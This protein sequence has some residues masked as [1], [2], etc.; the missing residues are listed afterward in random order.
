MIDATKPASANAAAW[1][2]DRHVEAGNGDRVAI[3]GDELTY[4]GLTDLAARAG[5]A[6]AAAG[7]TR[8]ERVMVV[9]PDGIEAVACALGAM[10]A[11]AVPVLVSPALSGDEQLHVAR[12]CDA[13]A[14]VLD[15]S[16]AAGPL[17]RQAGPGRTW[18]LGG[19]AGVR[20]LRAELAGATAIA[21]ATVAPDELALLQ[22]TSGSSGRPKGV[23]HL[24]RGLLAA[25]ACFGARLGLTPDD[26]VLST[27]KLPFGYGFGN[28]V[29]F[30]LAAGG[31]VV[32]NSGPP[33][34][35]VVAGLLRKHRPTVLCAVPAFYGAALRLP[36]ARERLDLTSVRLLVSAGEHLTAQL[37]EAWSQMFGSE[38]V[39][40]L[41]S[42]ECLHIFLATVAG[43]SRAG[44]SG[45]P[46]PGCELR[47]V[48][49][50]GRD[51]GCSE[52]GRLLVRSPMNGVGYWGRPA[53]TSATFTDG[54]V[55]TGDVLVEEPD[56]E[57][58][59]LAR[60]D[61]I[62]NAGGAKV[63]PQDVEA[64]VARHPGVAD[65]AVVSSRTAEYGLEQILAFVVAHEDAGDEDDLVRS[66]RRHVRRTLP[67]GR[68]PDAIVVIDEL[69]RTSTGKLARFRL[70]TLTEGQPT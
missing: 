63:A 36:N 50:D 43:R 4:A 1:L 69:P 2:L 38:I 31:S 13:A 44:S 11:G 40:G 20:D 67:P 5:G 23:I 53:A 49:D 17:L 8:G 54:W 64:H 34:V 3:A 42:T 9:L 66:L 35:H 37:A 29:L 25:P 41:G 16:R 28:S 18:A 30:P 26:R 22:Y 68:R 51:P 52:P 65:C 70:R 60:N 45:R 24:H 21:P 12:D 62:I 32:L 57:W 33:E 19:G 56:G 58:R 55:H 39:N 7:V 61:D 6:L 47:L 48:D 59:Y 10:R 46:V 15:G 27:A 14:I